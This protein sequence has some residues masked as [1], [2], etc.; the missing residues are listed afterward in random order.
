MT[1]LQNHKGSEQEGALENIKFSL[2]I[3]K[4]REHKTHREFLPYS[5]L[6]NAFFQTAHCGI[7]VKLYTERK[8]VCH[9][10]S[11]TVRRDCV[12]NVFLM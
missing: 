3:T 11:K 5:Y 10:V 6:F 12:L 1:N 7:P 4:A 2:G 8:D 9:F